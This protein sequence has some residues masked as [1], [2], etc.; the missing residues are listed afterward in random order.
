MDR[1]ALPSTPEETSEELARALQRA[2]DRRDNGGS[3]DR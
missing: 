1:T 3:A 2:L